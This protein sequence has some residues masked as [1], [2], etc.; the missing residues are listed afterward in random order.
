MS[1]QKRAQRLLRSWESITNWIY[2]M[3]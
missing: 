3:H 1:S 2:T